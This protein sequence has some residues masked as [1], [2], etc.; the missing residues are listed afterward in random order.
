MAKTKDAPLSLRPLDDRVVVEQIEAFEGDIP[1]C[2]HCRRILV[3]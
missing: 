2:V 1:R 3:A